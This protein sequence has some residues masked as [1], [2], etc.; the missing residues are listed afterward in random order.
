[1]NTPPPEP[2]TREWIARTIR[3]R[4]L[5]GLGAVPRYLVQ[6]SPDTPA[7]PRDLETADAILE[8]VLARAP[9]PPLSLV[10]DPAAKVWDKAGPGPEIRPDRG[11]TCAGCG[12]RIQGSAVARP[13]DGRPWHPECAP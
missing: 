9:T 4:R 7:D 12:H 1:M 3:T 2:G 13:G 10:W 8:A 5:Q 11:W 6:R